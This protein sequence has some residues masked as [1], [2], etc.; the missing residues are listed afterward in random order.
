MFWANVRRSGKL[1]LLV[2]GKWRAP[3]H[4]NICG[5][6]LT[7]VRSVS[8]EAP[9]AAS[10]AKQI[11]RITHRE[12]T[13]RVVEEEAQ[14]KAQKILEY[15]PG[16]T[17]FKKA[18]YATLTAGLAAFLVTSGI[19]IPNDETLILAAFLIVTRVLYVKLSAPITNLI[20]STINVLYLSSFSYN[21]NRGQS[22]SPLAEPS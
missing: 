19:Y 9:S 13:H 10:A 5:G 15:F 4:L 18:T 21:R 14:S 11:T 7:L 16:T 6:C 22:C 3:K 17:N 12:S 1:S 8:T 2:G 20:D